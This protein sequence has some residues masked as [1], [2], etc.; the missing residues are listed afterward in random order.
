MQALHELL[1]VHGLTHRLLVGV[2]IGILV[3]IVAIIIIVIVVVIVSPLD[4]AGLLFGALKQP[5]RPP[6]AIHRD[7]AVQLDQHCICALHAYCRRKYEQI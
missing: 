3:I 5:Q 7:V 6:Q 1:L 4:G 2:G